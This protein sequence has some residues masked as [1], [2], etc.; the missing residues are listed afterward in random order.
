MHGEVSLE[1]LE[2]WVSSSTPSLNYLA[3]HTAFVH[4][5][6]VTGLD[7][8]RRLEICIGFFEAALSGNYGD[9]LPEGP[10]VLAHTL[11]GWLRRLA[12]SAN[13]ADVAAIAGIMAMLERLVRN[14]SDATRDVIVLGLLEHAFEDQVTRKLFWHWTTDPVLA[15]LYEEAIRLGA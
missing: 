6:D 2:Q 11:L 3:F 7:E 13:A 10:Y 5:D 9:T 1:T 8:R 4:P 15:P 12:R 14:G